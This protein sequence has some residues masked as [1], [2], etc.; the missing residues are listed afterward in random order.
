VLRDG[1]AVAIAPMPF[2][3][4]CALVRQPGSPFGPTSRTDLA[5]DSYAS[6]P[7]P[8]PNP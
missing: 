7:D 6:H 4:L 2:A 1:M 3:V 8:S 5:A